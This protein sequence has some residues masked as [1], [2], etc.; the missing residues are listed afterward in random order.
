MKNIFMTIAYDGSRYH[1]WQRQPVDTNGLT[2][3]GE[4]E[5]VLTQVIGEPIT[6]DGTSR[7]DAGVHAYGQCA[8][9][10]GDFS[11]PADRIKIAA[12]NYLAGSKNRETGDIRIT[13]IKEVPEGFHARF[14]AKGKEYIYRISVS[15][16]PDV[17]RKNYCYQ[18]REPLDIE[19][20]RA[21]AQY[22]VGTHDFKCFQA[23][24]GEEKETTVRTI[25]SLAIT[26]EAGGEN[27]ATGDITIAVSGDG[28]LYNMVRIIVG[29]LV[30]VGYGKRTPESVKDTIESKDRTKAGFTAPPQGLYL[31]RVYYDANA[32]K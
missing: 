21:A 15:P 12:N 5:R 29:T 25:H 24:G 23:S 10:Q 28:F 26:G 9:F 13:D 6:I 18:L 27:G 8:T 17:F 11:I 1:G 2:V 19:A 7:T 16:E 3:Q 32:V 20:M 31:N 14:D 30:E 4:L 22:I